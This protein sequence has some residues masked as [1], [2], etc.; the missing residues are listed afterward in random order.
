MKTGDI[1]LVKF[2]PGYGTEFK[3]YRPAIVISGKINAIDT[4]F[5]LIA[6]LTTNL[7]TKNPEQEI[8]ISNVALEKKSLLLTWYLVTVDAS[9]LVRKL[10]E[11]SSKDKKRV[12]EATMRLFK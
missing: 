6:P 3:K 4:R 10:G 1:Y 9:R 5:A 12:I 11:L 2:H 7:K 8:D